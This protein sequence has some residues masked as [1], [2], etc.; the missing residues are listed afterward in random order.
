VFDVTD[1]N[2]IQQVAETHRWGDTPNQLAPG[3][4][5]TYDAVNH[6]LIAG[7]T[8]NAIQAFSL[9]M[10]VVLQG[11]FNAETGWMS[12]TLRDAGHVPLQQPY[13]A[14]PW[15]YEGAEGVEAMPEGVVDW[16]LVELRQGSPDAAM[17]TARRS[18][19]LLFND[20][21]IREAA[22][23]A[24][25]S[26]L[27]LADGDYHVVIRHRNH[28]DVMSSQAT[29]FLGGVG[30]WDFRSTTMRAHGSDAMAMLGEGA[31]GLWSGDGN[32]DGQVTAPDFNLYNTGTALGEV[33]YL[34]GDYNL[35]GQITAPDFNLFI[36]A[37][38][39]GASTGVPE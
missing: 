12:T 9:G 21:S 36:Q 28:I 13:N 18:A 10:N 16:V 14:A 4:F 15:N 31:F 3:G 37:T 33:G 38:A 25:M 39:A 23:F 7:V 34:Q 22:G 24:P 35:D 20:G 27:G 2:D 5:V 6:L 17:T 19:A 32:A 1:I 11:A 8:N 26:F 30:L 29:P